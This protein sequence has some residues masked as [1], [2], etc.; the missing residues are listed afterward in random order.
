MGFPNVEGEEKLLLVRNRLRENAFSL[1][2]KSKERLHMHTSHP[3]WCGRAEVEEVKEEARIA[4]K[5]WK[6]IER[7]LKEC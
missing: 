4:F 2:R 7:K 6:A 3:E 1:L 5:R